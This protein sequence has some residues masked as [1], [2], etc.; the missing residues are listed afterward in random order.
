MSVRR[1]VTLLAVIGTAL[2]SPVLVA[3]QA[4]AAG[5]VHGCPSGAVCIYPQNRGW[6]GDRPGLTFWAYGPHNLSNLYGTHRVLNNQ[7]GGAQV[8]AC[9]GYNGTG[10]GTFLLGTVIDY[11]LTPVNSLVLF[12]ANGSGCR[13]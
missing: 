13:R 6:N 12:P 2:V 8:E 1:I 7:Y 3:P 4:R 9:F 11:N 10:R 5:A